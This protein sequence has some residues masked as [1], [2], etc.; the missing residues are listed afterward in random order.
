MRYKDGQIQEQN[1]EYSDQQNNQTADYQKQ[2]KP[3][4]RVI[5]MR[6]QSNKKKS[7]ESIYNSFSNGYMEKNFGIKYK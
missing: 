6:S 2:V 7:I 1:N 5:K 3:R 4:K